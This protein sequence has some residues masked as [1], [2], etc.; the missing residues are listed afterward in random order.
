LQ[1]APLTSL[2]PQHV[3]VLTLAIGLLLLASTWVGYF[4]T[5]R[6]INHSFTRSTIASLTGEA[7]LLDEHLNRSL[8]QITNTL[9]S[10]GSLAELMPDS[11][12]NLTPDILKQ[13]LGNTRLIRSLSI[14]DSNDNVLTSSNPAN[15]GQMLPVE[16]SVRSF[17]DRYSIQGSVF[18]GEI[19]P[20]RDLLD[21]SSGRTSS[22]QELIPAY[23]SFHKGGEK[24]TLIAA[25]NV[26]LFYNLWDRINHSKSIEVAVYNY[27]G[28][29]VIVRN[30]NQLASNDVFNALASEIKKQQIGYF[31]MPQ[32]PNFWVF[33]RANTGLPKILVTIANMDE[34]SQDI[35]EEDAFLLVLAAVVSLFIVLILLATY[36]LYLRHERAAIFTQNLLGGITTHLM[37]TRADTDGKIQDVNE[38]LLIA[39]GY[40]RDELIGQNHRIFKSGL[41][42]DQFYDKLWKTI[43]KGNI[44][45]GTFR[46]KTK[47]GELLWM[48]ATIVPFKNEWGNISSYVAMYSDVTKA[49]LLA[50]DYERERKTRQALESLNQQLL[51]DATKDPLTGVSNRRGLDQFI[52]EITHTDL[53][54]GL[55]V[56]VLMLDLDNFKQIND[57]WGHV[58]GDCVLKTLTSIWKDSIRSSDLLVRLGGEEFAVILLRTS[59]EGAKNVADLLLTRT[60]DTQIKVE[61]KDEAL[62][63]TVSIGVAHNAKASDVNI[64]SLL[65]EA[66]AA[67]YAAKREGKNQV[68]M[69]QA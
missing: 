42:P 54:A 17:D 22:T 47:A 57:T 29:R 1:I 24:Y 58:V 6:S 32:N 16:A 69:G 28:Q 25:I 68:K 9:I 41:Q 4:F 61:G 13:L 35:K 23:L 55:S 60:R 40:S 5:S 45:T 33:Y 66:D 27:R 31:T 44:W 59:L 43:L 63:V 53:L 65:K 15:I 34:L 26:S 21:W 12:A 52:D 38:P 39:T 20:Y 7:G 49:A 30:E 56:S 2:K 18:F 19:L 48:N 11:S 46:N 36:R 67:L 50:Q 10:A 8:N 51:S 64:E 3:R 14:L 37:M 62:Y